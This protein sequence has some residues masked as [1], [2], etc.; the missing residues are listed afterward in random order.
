MTYDIKIKQG[1]FP[2]RIKRV[3]GHVILKECP[4]ILMII[5]ENEERVFIN[6]DKCKTIDFS[7]GW[8]KLELENVKRDSNGVAQVNHGL[9]Q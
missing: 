7:D 4:N 8:F 9:K 5:K 3:K 6:L 1:L 2:R